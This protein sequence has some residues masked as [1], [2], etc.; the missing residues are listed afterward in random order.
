MVS[1]S[2]MTRASVTLQ[3]N[4]PWVPR[5][6]YCSTLRD[7]NALMYLSRNTSPLPERLTFLTFKFIYSSA[8]LETEPFK[9]R[10]R[11]FHG[12]TVYIQDTCLLDYVVRVIG[13]V[14]VNCYT[15]RIIGQ[16]SNSIYDQSVVTFSIVGG[17]NIET[18]SNTV[19]V[20]TYSFLFA[21][22]SLW[23]C[24]LCRVHQSLPQFLFCFSSFYSR[25]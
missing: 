9:N 23:Q 21:R 18:V 13:F 6:T 2:L 8:G 19:K 7:M 17:Y 15:V 20:Q 4:M 1:W 3:M 25:P 10:E 16:L 5:S 22:V 11:C 24:I 14:D 12:Q